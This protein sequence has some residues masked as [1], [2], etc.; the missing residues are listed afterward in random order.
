MRNLPKRPAVVETTIEE[1]WTIRRLYVTAFLCR[2]L[3]IFYARVHD[4]VFKV[5][6]TDI[7]YSVFSDAA[8]HVRHGR[9]PFDRA[10]YRYSPILAFMLWP[11]AIYQEFGKVLFCSIDILT[12]WLLFSIENSRIN[13]DKT[14]EKLK[15]SLSIFWL[16][17]PFIAIISS[18]G[19]ADTVVCAAVSLV[20]WLLVSK[21]WILAAIAHG[22]LAIH[23]KIYPIIYLPAVFISLSSVSIKLTIWQNFKAMLTN[24][25]GFIY[26]TVAI[27]FFG[28]TVLIGYYFYGQK[29]LDEYLLYHFHRKDLKHNFS[30]YFYPIYLASENENLSK[31]LGFGA[32]IPQ[33]ILIVFFAFRYGKDLPFCWF[34]TTFSFVSLNKVCTSQYFVWYLM[35]L[36]L[37]ADRITMCS[38]KVIKLISLWFL[39]QGLWLLPAY[40]L[41]F[42]GWPVMQWV[43]IASLVFLLINFYILRSVCKSYMITL[44]TKQKDNA[45]LLMVLYLIGLGLGDVQD[46]TVRGLN[47]VK[48]CHRVYLEAYTSI[49]S[50]GYG[51]DKTKLEEFYGR[52]VLEA[53]RDFVEQGCGG[54]I[55]EA[56]T[57]DIALLVVGDPFGATTHSDLFLRANEFGTEVRVVHNTSILNAIGCCGLQLYSFGEVV[58]IVFWTEEWRP[59][60][61][62]DKI[63]A[64][65]EH[66]LHTLCLLDIKVKEQSVENLIKNRKIYEPP[67]FLTCAA[68]ATQL[69][70]I[71]QK[72]TFKEKEYAITKD[73]KVVGL[74]RIGWETQKIAYCSLKQMAEL[75][76]GP[77]LHSLIVP[78]HHL[79]PLEEDVLNTFKVTKREGQRP[80]TCYLLLKEM[81]IK[82]GFFGFGC[83]WGESAFA[84]IDGVLNTRVGYAG[85]VVELQFDE[86]VVPYKDLVDYF[87]QHHDPTEPHK[88]Q[89]RS[90]ILW[91]DEDQKNVAENALNELKKQNPRV[92]TKVEKLDVF[93]EAEAYHQKLRCQ[94]R[95]FGELNLNDQETA[96]SEL[97]TKLNAFMAGYQ[98][99]SV[100]KSLAQKHKLSQSLVEVVENIARSGGDPRACH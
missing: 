79:H 29:F 99:F 50:Y 15:T 87:F 58:S 56:K 2:L 26:C 6:F 75:D 16:F 47:I 61:F 60:S 12:G 100:L 91:N 83:F 84:K 89:Y 48:K 62:F 19:N 28:L 31:V 20:L 39:G 46:I 63:M 92:Q 37:I 42:K 30:P 18:R 53:D 25:R 33:L 76:L 44:H 22:L 65:R 1:D 41:E 52:E 95:I 5:K 67:R 59:E 4:Y 27:V 32:F 40:L 80:K 64:N 96:Q 94:R 54:M 86:S 68:A 81:S 74:A 82:K 9:S 98:N 21:R 36:P 73:T 69:M 38:T 17:N 35:F 3:L 8:D 72:G 45:D 49:L 7:D 23:L 43:W 13:D 78:S 88:A 34:V 57:Y 11:N 51:T 70:E 24:W 85:E 93:Y 90:L 77:P 66:G 97:S 10:T 71:V 55:E 14:R